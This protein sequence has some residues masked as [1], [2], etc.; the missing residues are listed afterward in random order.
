[1]TRPTMAT[2]DCGP[3]PMQRPTIPC[4]R[5]HRARRCS[6]RTNALAAPRKA[7]AKVLILSSSVGIEVLRSH[8]AAN[9]V[10]R[11]VCIAGRGEAH[12]NV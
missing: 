1:M 7:S 3:A 2:A 9:R 10:L 8:K 12:T 5:Q 6:Q 4:Q 11:I